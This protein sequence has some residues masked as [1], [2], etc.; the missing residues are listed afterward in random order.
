MQLS[1][2]AQ[3]LG[4]SVIREMFNEALKMEDTISFTVGEPDFITPRPIIEE[5]CRCWE[6]GMTHYTPNSGVLELRQ[7]I[8]EY[9]ANDLKPDPTNQIMVSCGATEAIQMALFT[10]VNPGDEVIVITPAWPN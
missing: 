1:N 5:A 9:H 6:S 7:A 8:A 10:L 4:G 3:N 2:L